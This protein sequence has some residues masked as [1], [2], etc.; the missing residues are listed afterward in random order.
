MSLILLQTLHFV[1]LA[2][3][4]LSDLSVFHSS[5]L[6]AHATRTTYLL[7]H[8]GDSSRGLY[9]VLHCDLWQP[10]VRLRIFLFFFFR[11]IHLDTLLGQHSQVTQAHLGTLGPLRHYWLI[12][13]HL[14]PTQVTQAHQANLAH[15]A[16][17]QAHLGH[18]GI[19]GSLG[20]TLGP[21]GHLGPFRHTWPTRHHLRY[22]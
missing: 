9:L 2:H 3:A 14:R 11:I 18:L 6:V 15:Q 12:R 1:P 20:T 13:H 17:P 16:P 7:I 4:L 21:L 10:Q 5:S 22:T 8:L 19:L